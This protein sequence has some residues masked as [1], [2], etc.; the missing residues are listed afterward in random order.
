MTTQISPEEQLQEVLVGWVLA[1]GSLVGLFTQ[2]DNFIDALQDL[3]PGG[4]QMVRLER[5]SMAV[6]D[7]IRHAGKVDR[8][9]VPEF[10]PADRPKKARPQVLVEMFEG[11]ISQAR[12]NTP[13]D[14]FVWDR[15][16]VREGLV[17]TALKAQTLQTVRVLSEDEPDQEAVPET[18]TVGGE[19]LY[20]LRV[21]GKVRYDRKGKPVYCT[22][23]GRD[24]EEGR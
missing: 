23:P 24:E 15:S 6:D 17:P 5:L 16:E 14:V 11:V 21:D 18:K 13:V 4:D 7:C 19:T 1:G 2:I 9:G 12:C 3:S 22:I 10:P 8:A 20:L